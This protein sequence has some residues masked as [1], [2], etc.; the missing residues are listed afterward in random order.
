MK[1][2]TIKE[3]AQKSGTSIATV[4]RVMNNPEKVSEP[5]RN[6]ILS[7][8]EEYGYIQNRIAK[9]LVK[10][11]SQVIAVVAPGEE[12]FFN[13]YYF[14]GLFFG[15]VNA[16]NRLGYNVMVNQLVR[17]GGCRNQFP[18]DG[19]IVIS[20]PV[21][22][23]FLKELRNIDIPVVLIGRKTDDISYVDLDNIQA[24]FRMTSHLIECG[25]DRIVILTG[26]KDIQNSAER[27]TGYRKALD[28]AGI[29]PDDKYIIDCGFSEDT[30]YDKIGCILSEGMVFTAVMACNDLMAIG[31]IRAIHERKLDVPEDISVTGF[32]DMDITS[33]FSPR[34]TTFSQPLS[35]MG[36]DSV[37]LL[38]GHIEGHI[39]S[40]Q[41][42]EFTGMMILRESH[43]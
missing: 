3:I 7:V 5:V 29:V 42:K 30:A 34:L 19:Y 12:E 25:H 18:V 15:I 37:R 13:A 24:S 11:R 36:E 4:S 1:N 9:G 32:D 39:T 38:V 33:Y 28:T 21:G 6:K 31:A 14:K 20:P 8:M 35:A 17:T 26:G 10:G 23:P 43:K 2:I 41:G 27:V 22:D 16:A 40:P